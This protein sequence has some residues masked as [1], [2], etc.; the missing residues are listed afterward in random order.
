MIIITRP[1]LRFQHPLCE[2]SS[3][4]PNCTDSWRCIVFFLTWDNIR[5]KIMMSQLATSC[6][7]R[8][9]LILPCTNRQVQHI[10]P[11]IGS[12]SG[13]NVGILSLRRCWHPMCASLPFLGRSRTMKLMVVALGPTNMRHFVVSWMVP[14]A[15]HEARVTPSILRS[16]V[17]TQTIHAYAQANKQNLLT[18][19]P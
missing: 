12:N 6:S 10:S 13:L 4:F 14:W 2:W 7:C 17:L 3:N 5:A 9:V 18:L 8:I 19:G 11:W 1:F 15:A 16:F